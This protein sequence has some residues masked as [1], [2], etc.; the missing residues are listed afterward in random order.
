MHHVQDSAPK[1]EYVH[2]IN[3]GLADARTLGIDD[4]YIRNCIRPFIPEPSPHQEHSSGETAAAGP[5][6]AG[7]RVKRATSSRTA[8]VRVTPDAS[9]ESL[10]A[11]PQNALILP[12]RAPRRFYDVPV[13]T[14]EEYVGAWD[15]RP[16]A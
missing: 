8:L 14:V 7:R 4:D 2:R 3:L 1:D 9:S 15:W 12:S 10:Q 6:S 5:K 16:S 11:R 13:I